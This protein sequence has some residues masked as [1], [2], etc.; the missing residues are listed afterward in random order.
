MGAIIS[1]RYSSYKS[2][3]KVFKLLLKFLL[4]SPHKSN[5]LGFWNFKF[6]TFNF[7]SSFSWV[8]MGVKNLQNSAPPSNQYLIL[9][10]FSWILFSIGKLCTKVRD[11][12]NFEFCFLTNFWN[13][14]LCAMGKPKSSIIWKTS[15]RRA[16][17]SEICTS[18][19][20]VQC[21]QVTCDG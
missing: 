21:I 3:P 11:F 7:F 6:T 12:W 13:S 14:P 18:E 4:S 9:W 17:L 16:K 8:L 5:V 15:D 2:Q 1:K 10:N 20:S 19:V